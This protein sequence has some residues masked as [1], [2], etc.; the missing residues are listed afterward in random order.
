MN[1][2][3]KIL[4][5]DRYD[6]D[7]DQF[8]NIVNSIPDDPSDDIV[9][10]LFLTFSNED[11]FG[12]QEKVLNKLDQLSNNKF[13]SGLLRNFH[14]LLENSSE[15]E[16]P[17]LIIGRYI[18]ADDQTRIKEIIKASTENLELSNF[19]RSDYFQDEYPIEI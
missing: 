16:W 3:D 4:G 15:Q 7:V 2:K 19:L 17:L 18:N 14:H 10:A 5:L 1:F 11:D 8:I 6:N 9:D 13:I 12:V